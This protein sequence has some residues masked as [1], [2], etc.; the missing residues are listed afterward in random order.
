MANG[1]TTEW[2]DLQVKYGN[3]LPNE[4]KTT[5]AEE[6]KLMQEKHEEENKLENKLDKMSVEK[7]NELEDDLDFDDEFTRQYMAN[8]MQELKVRATKEKYGQ[9]IEISRDEYIREV[10]EADP[11]SFVILHLYQD[12]NEFCNLINQHLPV[13]AKLYAHVKFVKIVATKC[14]DQFPDE[15]CPCFIIY[16]AGKPVSNLPS[17]DKLLKNDVANIAELLLQHGISPL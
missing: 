9:V 16:K 13:I 14:I 3:Y 2:F 12:Y 15:R 1:V 11:E 4:K 5:L 10:T 7:I 6:Q 8:R 17:V